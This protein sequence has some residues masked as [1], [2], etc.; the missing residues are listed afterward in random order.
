MLNLA[1]IIELDIITP[2]ESQ[3]ASV[4][5]ALDELH[6]PL[7]HFRPRR[8]CEVTEAGDREAGQRDPDPSQ[9]Q[10]DSIPK[11]LQTLSASPSTESVSLRKHMV[12]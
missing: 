7:P 10:G 4:T 12:I 9:I 8:P 11:E 1:S 5:Q 6:T 2:M 3:S